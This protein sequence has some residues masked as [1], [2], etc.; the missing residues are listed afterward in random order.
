MTDIRHVTV[1]NIAIGND[2][3]L[4]LIAGPN[5]LE[6]ASACAGDERGAQGTGR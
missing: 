5:V 3:P 6:V 4:V 1:G 2:L